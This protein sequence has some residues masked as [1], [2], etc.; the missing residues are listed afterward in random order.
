MSKF[1]IEN[2]KESSKNLFNKKQMYKLVS[3]S[4]YTNLIDFNFG[5]KRLYGRVDKFFQPITPNESFFRLVELTTDTPQP[6][7]VFD[8]VADAFAD[9]QNRFKIKVARS[10]ISKDEEFLTDIV[11]VAAYQDPKQIYQ[12]YTDSFVIAVG[13]V[14]TN[15]NLKFTNFNEFVNVIMPYINNFLKENVITYPAFV[16]SR[17]CPYEH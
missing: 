11:P 13:N 15:N 16:K 12:K 2:D 6:V 9:L 10:E 3:K 14:I 7:K 4:G 8:F 1:F 17:T 5:E